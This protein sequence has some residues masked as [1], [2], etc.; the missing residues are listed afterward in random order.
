M[1]NVDLIAEKIASKA[2]N[3]ATSGKLSGEFKIKDLFDKKTWESF[4]VEARR[5]AGK[6]FK[7]YINNQPN[8]GFAKTNTANHSIYKPN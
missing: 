3:L 4:P 8:I 1:K 7:K 6:K 5:L 2:I